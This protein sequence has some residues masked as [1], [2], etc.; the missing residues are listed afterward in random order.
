MD[1]ITGIHEKRYD[2][3]DKIK[4]QEQRISKLSEHLEHVDIYKQ[5]KA[6][7]KKYK[8]LEPKKRGVF[9]EKHARGNCVI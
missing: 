4:A 2:L 1:K 8:S 5:N 9:I 7:Y 3:A 6:L